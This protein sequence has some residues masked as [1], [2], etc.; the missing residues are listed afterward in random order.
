MFV[1]VP[2]ILLFRNYVKSP[3]PSSLSTLLWCKPCFATLW[4][5]D[6]SKSLAVI[7]LPAL[8]KISILLVLPSSLAPWTLNSSIP[9]TFTTRSGTLLRLWFPATTTEKS[10]CDDGL[11]TLSTESVAMAMVRMKIAGALTA[12]KDLLFSQNTSLGPTADS[13]TS[14]S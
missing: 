5:A 4:A 2:L 11:P 7:A 12:G 9:F 13:R 14:R 10:E 6:E 8:E 3:S 1:S